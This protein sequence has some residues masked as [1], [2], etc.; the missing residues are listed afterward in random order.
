M[1]LEHPNAGQQYRLSR[2]AIR[3]RTFTVAELVRLTGTVDNTVYGF[4]S[5]LLGAPEEYLQWEELPRE[6]PGRPVKRYTVTAAGLDFLLQRNAR[7]AAIL[8]GEDETELMTVKPAPA[9]ATVSTK[10]AS[11]GNYEIAAME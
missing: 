4:V 7:F 3:L 10:A 5:K 9:R 8:S 6:T 2:L 1:N 11:A